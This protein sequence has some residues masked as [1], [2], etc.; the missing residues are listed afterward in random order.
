MNPERIERIRQKHR[1]TQTAIE[2]EEKAKQTAHKKA[3][4]ELCEA[5]LNL[6]ES[7]A[8]YDRIGRGGD[9]YKNTAWCQISYS[10]NDWGGIIKGTTRLAL[11]ED[12]HAFPLEYE[13]S[14]E[15][16]KRIWADV[17]AKFSLEGLFV[18]D[19]R[20]VMRLEED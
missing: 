1:A 13:Y 17:I 12:S 19:G 2:A 8:A 5:I 15:K 11:P 16:F 6:L 10:T 7:D 4:D 14:D 3:V 20:I 18:S 9:F